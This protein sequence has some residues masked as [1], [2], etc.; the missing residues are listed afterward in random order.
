MNHRPRKRFGQNFL[1]DGEVIQRIIAAVG[2]AEGDHVVEIGPGTGALTLPLL[3]AGA[4]VT[5]VEIDR[6]LAAGLRER[7]S[8]NARARV[9][10]ADALRVDWQELTEGRPYRLV[11]NLPYNISTPLMFHVLEATHLPSDM[12]FMLQKEV[13][14][15][16]AAAPGGK[17]YGRLGI[18]CQNRCSVAPLFTIGREAF[19]PRPGVDSAFVR[20]RPH[21][22]PRSGEALAGTLDEVVRQ[23]FSQRRKTLRNSLAPLFGTEEL[24]RL[25]IDP[26]SRAETLSLDDYITLARQLAQHRSA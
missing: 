24:E 2:P 10:S 22:A 25:G 5:V 20:L 18:A 6:D 26:G 8:G 7:L 13:V 15:R 3:D 12:H 21:S 17:D 14:D 1:V 23:A 11:G 9:V 16:L 19:D 4:N